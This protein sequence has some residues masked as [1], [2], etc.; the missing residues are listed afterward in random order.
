MEEHSSRHLMWDKKYSK[1]QCKRE[2]TYIHTKTLLA[3]SIESQ[4]FLKLRY[5]T[6]TPRRCKPTIRA[7]QGCLYGHGTS[8]KGRAWTFLSPP[9]HTLTTIFKK[10]TID[11][12]HTFSGAVCVWC[13]VQQ[14]IM[15]V[16]TCKNHVYSRWMQTY[17]W[18]RSSWTQTRP[19]TYIPGKEGWKRKIKKEK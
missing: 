12:T 3:S 8:G 6:W 16:C 15:S 18:T 19:T 9:P 17:L 7:V 11:D 13:G 1:G 4:R 5:G 10:R 2:C 14:A